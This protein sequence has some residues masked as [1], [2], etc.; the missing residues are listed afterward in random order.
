MKKITLRLMVIW[1]ILI[2]VL[3]P[4]FI[5]L[6]GYNGVS[7]ASFLV[8]MTIVYTAFLVKKIIN[9]KFFPSII[10]P[11]TS[12]ILM[13]VVVYILANIF[14]RDFLSLIF[15]ILGGGVVYIVSLFLIARQEI[16]NDFTKF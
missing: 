8:T 15:V 16:K 6:Y 11:L 4:I 9:F 12:T 10:K 3:T 7:V 5:Y 13:T 14:A 2:W 1:T